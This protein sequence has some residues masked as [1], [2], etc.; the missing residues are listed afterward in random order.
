MGP[1]VLAR[2]LGDRVPYAVKI[3]GSALE[4]TVR[5]NPE[6]FLPYASEGLDRARG[7]LV[8]SH[9]SAESLWEVIGDE[10]LPERTR[11]GPPGVD[12]HTFRPLPA[13]EARGRLESLAAR[14]EGGAA[15]S[16]GGERGA[17]EALRSLDPERDRVVGY[18]GKLIV[19]KGVDLL[20]AAWPLVVERVPD[21]RLLGI[22]FGTDRDT[23]ER[24]RAAL[25]QR[26]LDTIYDIAARGRELEGG[27][28]SRL[29]YLLLFLDSLEGAERERYLEGAVEAAPRVSFTGRLE[30]D[31]LPAV[32]PASVA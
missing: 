20:L 24:M 13:A 7:V 23:L 18:V 22:G 27:E 30:H 3:H 29:S 8:G 10:Q 15:A 25:G 31:D 32:L 2:A 9:H 14:L 19:S 16:W 1:A 21:A 12:I 28:A 5:P 6:R 4:Y 11:L 26:D 17:A